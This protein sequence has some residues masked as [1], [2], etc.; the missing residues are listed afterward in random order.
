[1]GLLDLGIRRG[2]AGGGT[3]PQLT[4]TGPTL[5]AEGTGGATNATFTVTLA[6]NGF[7]GSVAFGWS[8]AGTGAAPVDPGDFAGGVLPSGSGTFAAGETV[9]TV[10]LSIAGDAVVE[11]DETL[12][13]SVTATVPLDVATATATIGNDDTAAAAPA[14]LL[15]GSR[16]AQPG[17]NGYTGSDGTD[18]DSNAR[19][20]SYNETGAT[21]TRLRAYFVNW[22]A[23]ATSEQD[24]Y[25]SI[26][27]RAAVEYPA[28]TFTPLA[29]GGTA[30]VAIPA[31]GTASLAE[32]DE[33]VLATP[34]PAG[35][36]YW[37]RT[38]VS[39]ASGGRW[40]QAYLIM[41]SGASGLGDA[42]DF[43]TGVD[44]TQSGTITN[45]TASATRRGYGP[46]AVKATGFDGTPVARAFAAVGDS[47]IMGAND[48]SDP[49]AVGHGNAGYF[50]KAAAGR[51]P[52]LN[53]GISGTA[54][55]YNLPA[56]FTRRAA[57]LAKVGV[58]HVFCDWG[59]ND[60]SG[61]RSAAQI[62]ADISTIARGFKNAVPGV[63][64][65]WT[66][67]TP[68]TTST[69][70]FRTAG[71]QSVHTNSGFVG[72]SS[73]PRATVNAA[74]RAG[75]IVGVDR[76][77]EAADAVE[78]NAANVPTRDGGLWISGNGGAGATSQ[79]LTTTGATSDV[80]TGD[81]LHPGVIN[82]ASPGYG[83]IYIL[84]DAVRAVFDGW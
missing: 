14:A 16:H 11:A 36:L 66:T 27:V 47:I 25:N 74:L 38:W 15:M 20:G 21:V 73:S 1:M 19:I 51:Y 43:N 3:M 17:F 26:T 49:A 59:I 8:V 10:T 33:A 72:G 82:T 42:V 2:G 4:V 50:A 37:V 65:T 7:T 70:G 29:F 56:A 78:V 22:M 5:I 83:G 75:N 76:V 18:T 45:A 35:A 69:D 57:L 6:R 48:A 13:L 80:A 12:R 84:R 28:G 40:P 61:G 53:L 44:R 39:V 24:G 9:K 81:G 30:A 64:V 63:V 71:A 55:M 41:A 77:F 62:Q 23:T 32:S 52:V 79:H 54:A 67:L 60:V 58:T 68:R 31:S 46:V 34:I